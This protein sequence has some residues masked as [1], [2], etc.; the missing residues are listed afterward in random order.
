M[1]FDI[2]FEFLIFLKVN[3]MMVAAAIE[4]FCW[5]IV[6]D[7]HILHSCIYCSFTWFKISLQC[8]DVEYFKTA[9]IFRDDLLQ[10]VFQKLWTTTWIMKVLKISAFCMSLQSFISHN[11]RKHVSQDIQFLTSLVDF[12]VSPADVSICDRSA[13]TWGESHRLSLSLKPICAPAHKFCC[14]S[15]RGKCRGGRPVTIQELCRGGD[16]EA[17]L[18]EENS[19]IPGG[20]FRSAS[21]LVRL[22]N[23]PPTSIGK[24]FFYTSRKAVSCFLFS[25]QL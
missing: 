10:N 20:T 8:T 11:F 4:T 5:R 25:L 9:C 1:H 15:D 19:G 7:K 22:N 21:R 23:A 2:L 24:H 6:C 14:N 12:D 18:T 13:L 16:P 17:N 3:L